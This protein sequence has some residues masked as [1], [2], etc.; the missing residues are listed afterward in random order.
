PGIEGA[1]A[2]L[3]F[4]PVGNLVA[5][6]A[7]LLLDVGV[8]VPARV[9]DELDA[10]WLLAVVLQADLDQAALGGLRRREAGALPLFADLQRQVRRLRAAATAPGDGRRSPYQCDSCEQRPLHLPSFGVWES[11]QTT[12]AN[13]SR[14]TP[15]SGPLK[16]RRA[17]S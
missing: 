2:A 5:V 1:D 12:D 10:V 17:Q 11:A 4:E 8:A 6:G 13:G 16:A 7:E 9:L 14:T 3:G 15:K